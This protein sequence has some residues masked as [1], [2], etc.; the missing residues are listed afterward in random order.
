MDSLQHATIADGIY[1]LYSIDRYDAYAFRHACENGYLATAQWLH[2]T[3][4]SN[5]SV[6]EKHAF[7]M[8]CRHGHL[9][10]AQW[11]YSI[12]PT[13]NASAELKC[14]FLYA[15]GQ[16]RLKLAMWLQKINPT[17]DIN[18]FEYALYVSRKNKHKKTCKWLKKQLEI[19][20]NNVEI[21][22][23]TFLGL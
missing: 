17:M 7:Q 11:L 4:P 22:I 6:N 1:A 21:Q 10:A 13:L 19:M 3:K 12:C 20:W 15:C 2:S 5:V 14:A 16:G 8:A 23:R 9:E 18:V